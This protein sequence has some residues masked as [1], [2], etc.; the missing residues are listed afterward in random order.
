MNAR[1]VRQI[2]GLR[3]SPM[4]QPSQLAPLLYQR[5]VETE[6]MPVVA[7][8]DWRQLPEVT[9]QRWVQMATLL[10]NR[11]QTWRILGKRN[12]NDHYR[13]NRPSTQSQGTRGGGPNSRSCGSSKL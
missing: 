7:V 13:Q 2:D 1:A 5:F 11:L 9:R 8:S 10:S 4:I 12:R 6:P 3:S